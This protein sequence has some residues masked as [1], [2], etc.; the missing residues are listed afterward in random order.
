MTYR[1]FELPKIPDLTLSKYES[2]DESGVD[3]VLKQIRSFWRLMNRRGRLMKE[4]YQL[5]YEYDPARPVG[6]RLR[7]GIRIDS[8]RN[9]P[10]FVDETI[11]SS[12][13]SPYFT[14]E[15]MK[16][17]AARELASR[18]YRYTAHL[19][20]NERFLDSMNPE[21]PTRYYLVSQWEMNEGAR[22]Y[23]MMKLLTAIDR[24][25]LYCVSI[26]PVDMTLR[27]R[28]NLSTI[29]PA[30]Q[31]ATRIQVKKS[32]NAV[33]MGE[34]DENANT[35]L[36]AY[37]ELIDNLDT[38]PH[39][40]VDVQ[41]LADDAD[42]ASY[43]LD[44]AAS[45][46]LTEGAHDIY[47]TEENF[48]LADITRANFVTSA[49]GDA[50]DQL[51]DLPHLYLLEE[52][53]C[54]GV[55]PALYP[56][57]FV[58]CPK[59]TLPK[60]E[61]QGLVLGEDEEGHTIRFPLKNLSKHA[62][63]AGV[64]GSGKTNSMMHLITSMHVDYGIPVL[65]LEPAKHEYRVL[66]S[67]PGMEDV[68]LFSPSARTQFPLHINPFQFPV[69]MTLAE[70]IRNLLS[71]FEGAFTLEPPMPF[72]LDRSVDEVYRDH[73][74]LP[75]MV[76]TGTLT[77]PT[78]QELYTKLEKKLEETDYGD[79]VRGNLK[80]AL[81][82][83]IGSLLTRE[84]GD[85]FDVP[86]SSVSPEKWLKQSAIIELE[87]MGPGPANFLTLMLATLIRETL[88]IE[89]YVKPE[90]G[91]PRHVMFFEEAHNLIGPESVPQ[92][93][94]NA[95]PK[96]AATGFIVKML[97]EV[98]ALGEG[99]VIA[100]Q[101]PTA[102]AP[103]V[104]KNTS[105]KIGLRITAQDDRGL[106]GG[107][108]S[109]DEVQLERMGVFSPGHALCSYEPLL[110]PFEIQIPEF[111]FKDNNGETEHLLGYLVDR[112]VY[113]DA[114]DKSLQ[115]SMGKWD[116]R[117]AQLKKDFAEFDKNALEL[118]RKVVQAERREKETGTVDREL[119]A[120]LFLEYQ[121]MQNRQPKLVEEIQN[122]ILDVFSYRSMTFPIRIQVGKRRLTGE[123]A[124]FYKQ[125]GQSLDNALLSRTA[126][127]KEFKTRMQQLK[128]V[129][130]DQQLE[131]LKIRME[132]FS[133]L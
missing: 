69:G 17:E 127:F 45:E 24:P 100:D 53:S 57:E 77:Y 42:L 81:Q 5:F 83:R 68:A 59:E 132:Q 35:A 87:S 108:M 97:A 58:D 89:T 102:M 48:S 90:D 120:K 22:L 11:A 125:Y 37:K 50:P 124:A 44:T 75:A 91:R 123:E 119:A 23:S 47:C 18:R 1:Y 84:M 70:H 130:Q 6:K 126:Y 55:F 7:I 29:M 39:F 62:F 110:K 63:L 104:I 9:D 54:F 76:N 73:N 41:V 93:G 61:A 10:A 16:E 66:T 106:L 96:V 20:K 40:L 118:G 14:L 82:V 86:Y 74:W 27:M 21:D 128:Y 101:L 15:P 92:P 28:D 112:K 79:E 88:K 95:D 98:R 43:V 36:E 133:N 117:L 103:E 116:R 33:G 121:N 30:L 26:Y 32:A 109:A 51:G 115:I 107:T 80:S 67:V 60:L 34:K 65:I 25:C 31:R 105:L 56:G 52:L 3:G 111:K 2:Q 49:S 114:L 78:L 19:L 38:T 122:C 94:A 113:M 131:K 8:Q 85:V 129:L 72:L 46:A 99:I 71:V 13:I 4:G 64:P 12:P